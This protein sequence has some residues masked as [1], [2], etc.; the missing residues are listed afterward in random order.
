MSTVDK[1][2]HFKQVMNCL[3]GK[4]K[5]NKNDKENCQL[6]GSFI[7]NKIQNLNRLQC[8]TTYSRIDVLDTIPESQT[9]PSESSD[10]DKDKAEEE[11]PAV[12]H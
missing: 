2:K 1:I 12:Q 11:E 4:E 5:L 10:Q 8:H 3:R 9:K 6:C 7:C